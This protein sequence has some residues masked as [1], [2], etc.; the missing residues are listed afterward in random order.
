MRAA[1]STRRIWLQAAA[2]AAVSGAVPAR[3]APAAGLAIVGILEGSA[4][5]IR[6][7][8]RF[9]VLEGLALQAED[10]V[11]TAAGGFAQIE[12]AD[13]LLIGLGDRSR[14][15]L[16]PRW[17]PS[18]ARD[19]PA[20]APLLY[21]LDGWLKFSQGGA[22]P[23]GPATR[24]DCLSPRLALNCK[25]ATVVLQ[26]EAAQSAAFVETGALRL[27]ERGGARGTLDVPAN[28]FVVLRAT[29]KPELAQRPSADFLAGMP[30][31]FRDPLPARAARFAG[32]EIVP[33]P[34]AEVSYD[35]V[36]AWLQ[37]EP[38][39]RLPLLKR[40]RG[41]AAD[42]AFRRAVQANLAAHPEWEPVVYPERFR[43]KDGG[44]A[45]SR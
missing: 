4:R 12:F 40:W 30:R 15:M 43:P 38:A 11:E 36:S 28:G 10:I 20:R 6:R 22:A 8:Q 16:A 35:D 21:L 3:A 7:A 2:L 42:P 33:K 41:R 13:G 37:A 23:A 5:L 32:R 1:V 27:A 24:G 19:K 9:A 44:S 25:D 18:A 29:G 45:G 31:P 39:L 14:L 17:T 26:L 34:L